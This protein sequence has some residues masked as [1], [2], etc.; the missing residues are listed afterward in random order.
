MASRFLITDP[1]SLWYLLIL[2]AILLLYMV[3]SRY[4]RHRISST[5]LWQSIRRDLESRQRLRLPP[6]SLLM[7]LEMMAVVVGTFALVRPAL[8]AENREHLVILVDISSS[9]EATDVSPSRFALAQEQA[10]QAIRR[11]KPGDLV[12]LV[13]MGPSPALAASGSDKT[14]LLA[15]LDH[16]QPGSGPADAIAA[17]RLAES[18]IRSTGGRGEAL[19]LSDGSF[20]PSVSIPRVDVPVA[21]SPIG[22][23]ADNQGITQLQVRPNLDGSGRWAAFARVASYADHPVQVRVTA[24]ADGLLVDSREVDLEAAASAELAFELPPDAKSFALALDGQDPLPADNQAEIQ[25]GTGRPRKVLVVSNNAAP[26][27]RVLQSLPE[28]KVSTLKPADYVDEAGADVVVLDGF[29]PADL[30]RAD[31]LIMNPPLGAPG[32]STSPGASPVQVLRARAGD[33]LIDSVDL[34]SLRLG[35]PVRID[36]PDWARSVVEGAVGPLILEGERAGRRIVLFDFD[37][38]LYDLP[39]MQA[40]PLLLSN[41]MARLDPGSLPAS[42]APGETVLIRPMADSMAAT[43]LLPDGARMEIDLRDGAQSFGETRQVGRYTVTWRGPRLGTVS[44]S[45]DVNVSSELVSNLQ[46]GE[47]S[48]QQGALPREASAPVAGLQLWPYFALA[49]LGLLCIEWA[50]FSRRG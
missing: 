30:P 49:M 27:Q 10:R 13:A 2:P 40:F 31:L 15:A 29:V 45:F 25:V 41:A 6:L 1:T 8:P 23:S 24:T 7:L 16:L 12:S 47:I 3:R 46:P 19:L 22:V 50:Y 48:F 43:V 14:E 34:Q 35:Q 39:K 9:M 33:P 21:Y 20:A 18:L 28:L 44:R 11:A 32:L 36:P 37:W 38:S 26:I 4:R 42:I 17:L 5:M